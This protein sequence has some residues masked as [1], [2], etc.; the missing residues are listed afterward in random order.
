MHQ[1]QELPAMQAKL[2]DATDTPAAKNATLLVPLSQP[3]G[4]VHG[5]VRLQGVSARAT[6]AG[7]DSFSQA[8]VSRLQELG[9]LVGGFLDTGAP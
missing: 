7:K 5:V 6:W 8:D 3:G 1:P 4:T 2:L 9:K